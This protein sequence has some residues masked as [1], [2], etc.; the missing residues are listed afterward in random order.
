LDEPLLP[1]DAEELQRLLQAH[2]EHLRRFIAGQIPARF[3]ALIS[4][5]DVLQEVWMEVFRKVDSFRNSGPNSFDRWLTTLARRRLADAIRR[6]GAEKRGGKRA[7]VG[8]FAGSSYTGLLAHVASPE[9]TPSGVLGE[10]EI[11][12]ALQL[13]LER[14]NHRRREVIRMRY[15]EGRS[16]ADIAEAVGCSPE[17]VNGLLFHGLEDLRRMIGE[18]WRFLSGV[19][20]VLDK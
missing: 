2:T 12:I 13:A 19:R 10:A 11:S 5:E 9:R 16:H 4:S 14:L 3:Q 15:L 18:S 20:R 8:E 6:N 1:V 7:H 17:A